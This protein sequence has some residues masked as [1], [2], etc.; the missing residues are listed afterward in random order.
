MVV[1]AKLPEH[2]KAGDQLR[3]AVR[4]VSADRVVLGLADQQPPLAPV[5][6]AVPLPGG[7][8]VRVSEQEAPVGSTLPATD[9]HTLTLRYDGPALGAV[10][11]RFEL[12]PRSLRVSVALPAGD[13]FELAQ[14]AA[15]QLRDQLSEALGRTISVSVSARHEPLDLYA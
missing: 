6:V 2:V 12:D 13:S 9:T 8:S 3:L 14:G 5:P 1:E 10:D 4:H 15:A 7:G 11:L